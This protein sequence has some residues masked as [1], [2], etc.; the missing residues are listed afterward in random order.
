MFSLNSRAERSHI[1]SKASCQSRAGPAG[2]RQIIN[3]KRSRRGKRRR[4]GRRRAAAGRGV[5]RRRASLGPHQQKTRSGT[6]TPSATRASET[7]TSVPISVA[8][9]GRSAGGRRAAPQRK[10]RALI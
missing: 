9:A 10:Y 5:E 6:K 4:A 3:V 7:E 8:S 2:R 1:E